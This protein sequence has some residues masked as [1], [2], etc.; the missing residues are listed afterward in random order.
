MTRSTS[1]NKSTKQDDVANIGYH[2]QCCYLGLLWSSKLSRCT[3]NDSGANNKD[4][5]TNGDEKDG[6][7]INGN[8]A[9]HCNKRDIGNYYNNDG[10]CT[11]YLLNVL[12]TLT[13]HC[14]PQDAGRFSRDFPQ[15]P[16]LRPGT[17]Q[18]FPQRPSLRPGFGQNSFRDLVFVPTSWGVQHIV[19]VYKTFSKYA[20]HIPSLLS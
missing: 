15:R 2:G 7:S 6:D 10:I 20:V 17:C 12:Y 9:N 18:D 16:S 14:T 8:N 1:P 19:N 5:N 11:V 13:I 3:N 4:I